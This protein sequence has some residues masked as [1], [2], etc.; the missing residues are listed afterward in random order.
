MNTM[1]VTLADVAE[2]LSAQFLAPLDAA[3]VEAARSV[4]GQLLLAQMG[5]LLDRPDEMGRL[6]SLLSADAVP[7]V[8]QGLQRSH[9]A[10][11]EGIFRNRSVAP[12]ASVWDGTGRLFGPAVER[13]QRLLHDLDIR[14][15]EGFHEPPDHLGVQ[16]QALAEALRQPQ[17]A[18]VARVLDE[19]AWT[20]RFAAA[21]GRLDG[22]GYFG[23]AARLLPPLLERAGWSVQQARV[24]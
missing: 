9:V 17:A 2:W 3:M 19:L 12:Y 1:T 22:D 15:D 13:M 7:V 6:R 11:F 8:V 4:R 5:A 10:L 16:L 21:L 20:E 24:A 14:L 23:V 18:R